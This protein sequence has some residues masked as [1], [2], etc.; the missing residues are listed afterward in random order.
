M[1]PR[2]SAKIDS[3]CLKTTTEGL[4]S[5]LGMDFNL[6]ILTYVWITKKETLLIKLIIY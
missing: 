3:L 4:N 5:S 2:T 6:C 1:S